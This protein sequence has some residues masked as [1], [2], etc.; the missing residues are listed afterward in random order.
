MIELVLSKGVKYFFTT[1]YQL[2]WKHLSSYNK[3]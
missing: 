2:S 3:Y 1:R